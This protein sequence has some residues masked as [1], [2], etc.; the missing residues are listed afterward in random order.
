MQDWEPVMLYVLCKYV[1]PANL[2]ILRVKYVRS[3]M[4]TVPM[5][6]LEPVRM[7]ETVWMESES[8]SVNVHWERPDLHVTK[9]RTNCQS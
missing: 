7:E 9:V 4:T 8:S 1:L 2:Q 5:L 3:H 6:G